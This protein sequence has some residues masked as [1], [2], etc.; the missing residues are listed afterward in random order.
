MPKLIILGSSNAVA[1]VNHENTH[2]A[3]HGAERILLIDCVGSPIVRLRRAGIDLDQLTDLLLTHFHPD[4]V[5]AVPL[6][7]MDLWLLGRRK[8][9]EIF[10]LEHTLQRLEQ[11]MELYSW[12]RW[13]NFFPVSFNRV[14]DQ[15]MSPIMETG[16][17][18]V[19]ASPVKHLIPTLG[20]R[21][22]FVESQKVLAYS[23]D[24]EPCGQ[25]VRLAHRA[26]VLIHEAT[27]ASA[28]HSSADQA[29]A[30]AQEAGVKRLYLIHYP[31]GNFNSQELALV[32]AQSFS[33]P[34]VLAEDLM[35]LEF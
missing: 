12:S 25:V 14:P 27:G 33:G 7:L 5:S 18:R 29:G 35:E 8:P 24:T 22:E 17:W 31:T 2:M 21:I 23:C 16:E 15:E 34:V 30:I 13:P 26:D 19:Y 9:L 11:V 4:H 6:F 20:V 28:G 32:A 3:V 10:G 1:D